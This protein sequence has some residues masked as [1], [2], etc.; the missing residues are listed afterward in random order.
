MT[1]FTAPLSFFLLCGI[2]LLAEWR[3][4]AA[5]FSLA[6]DR[7]EYTHILLV[8]PMVAALTFLDR[9]LLLSSPQPEWW[10]GSA[11]GLASVT[12]AALAKWAGALQP[13]TRLAL[14]MLAVVG[15][16]MGAFILCF[17][18]SLA[19][20]FLFPL[21]FLLWLV[22]IPSFLLAHII[23]FLQQ[24]SAYTAQ[25]LFTAVGVPVSQDGFFLT[26]PGLTVEVAKECS[27][28][29][30]SL[31]LVVTTMVL[32]Q[33][34]L[35]SFWRKALL[36]AVAVPLSVAKNGLRIFVIAMMGTRVDPS[37]LT[38]RLHHQGGII[39]L[40]IALLVIFLLLWILRKGEQR[41]VAASGFGP[42]A[43][44]NSTHH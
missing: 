4:L 11:F 44:L 13:D 25:L 37:Y 12:V 31:M 34:Q 3:A 36:V 42:V 9:R 7:E 1:K 6:A 15:W 30:S 33:L 20:A 43:P 18:P 14:A 23:T 29:R 27:S 5:T 10:W 8:L 32:A 2:S 28:I 24:W 35:R 17:G 26:I 38:G 39:F 21:G 41:S 22:P 40:L 16:W 19:R